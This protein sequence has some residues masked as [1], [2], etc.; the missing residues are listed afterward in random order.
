M[1]LG[2][3][4]GPVFLVLGLSHLF[5]AKTWAK[6]FKQWEKDH[7]ALMGLMLF[8]GVFGLFIIQMYNV[9]AWN[10]WVLVTITGWAWA[11]KAALYFLVPGSVL[12]AMMKLGQNAALQYLGGVAATVMGVALCYYTFFV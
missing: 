8:M 4:L 5:Y 12:K 6:L 9:W 11:V 1:M 7:L 3:V 10:V 2:A